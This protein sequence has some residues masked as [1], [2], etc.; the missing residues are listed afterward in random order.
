M[1]CPYC[2][3]ERIETGIAWGKQAESGKIGLK[4]RVGIFGEVIEVYSDLC[5]DCGSIVRSY[6]KDKTDKNWDKSAGPF[7]G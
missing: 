2:G 4:A 7:G 5:L 1:K 6:I 3:S